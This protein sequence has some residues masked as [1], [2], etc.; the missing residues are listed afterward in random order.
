MLYGFYGRIMKYSFKTGLG[1]G[2]TSGVITSLGLLVGLHSGTYSQLA[3]IG[4]IL[5]IAIADSFSDALGIHVSKEFEDR[6][7]SKVVWEATIVTF[8]TKFLIA[9]SFVVPVLLFPLSTAVFVG[10]MW[11]LLILFGFSYFVAKQIK[12]K[13]WKV[14]AEHFFIA[15]IVLV[16]SRW[17]GLLINKFF[18]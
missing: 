9:L 17:A 18:V 11:G 7:S 5:T 16:A 6:D 2:V 4:G 1:F 8:F 3:I 13:P 14:V 10:V 15:I 12:A